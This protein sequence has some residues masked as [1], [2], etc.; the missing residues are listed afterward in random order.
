MLCNSL[1]Q[2]HFGYACTQ[3]ICIDFC[4]RL[5]SKQLK[6]LK[7]FTGYKNERVEHCVSTKVFK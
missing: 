4:L 1:I 6:N 7:Q 5:N 3:N 2:P